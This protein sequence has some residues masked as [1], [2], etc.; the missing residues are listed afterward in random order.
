MFDRL[1]QKGVDTDGFGP[2]HLGLSSERGHHD[3]RQVGESGVCFYPLGSG[4]AVQAGHHP[5]HQDQFEGLVR[6]GMLVEFFQPLLPGS[7]Q[8]GMKTEGFHHVL[9]D[10]PVGLVV[11]DDEHL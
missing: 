9:H 3:D 6:N 5:V 8:L 10:G 11:I 4:Q 7:R 1:D 2:F